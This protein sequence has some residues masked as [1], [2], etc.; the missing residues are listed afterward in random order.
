MLKMNLKNFD[1]I[2]ISFLLIIFFFYNLNRIDYGL[3]FFINLDEN[4]FQ[5]SSLA[6]LK[7]ITGYSG[8]GY[9]PIYGP[10]LNLILILIFIFFNEVIINS[11]SFD[12]IQSKIYFNHELF[13]YYGRIASLTVSTLSIFI[14]YKIFRYLKIKFLIYSTLLISLSTSLY[15]L[16]ISVIN[17]KTSYFL[18]IFLIQLFFFIKYLFEIKK[19]KLKSYI[20]FGFLASLAWG[21]NY[22]AAFVSI[23]AIFFLH[24][25]KYKFFKIR[26]IFIF[27]IIFFIF[28]PLINFLFTESPF[29]FLSPVQAG[30][31]EFELSFFLNRALGDIRECFLIIFKSEKNI[32]LFLAFLPIFLLNK[33]IEIKKEFLIIFFLIFEPI[34]L[35][36]YSGEIFPQL[37]YFVG[38]FCIILISTAIIFNELD[39]LKFKYMSFIIIIFNFFIISNNIYLNKKINQ[40]I[41]KGHSFYQLNNTVI[42]SKDRSKILYLVDL[43]FRESLNQNLFYIKVYENDLIQKYKMQNDFYE[44]SKNKV[45]K[46]RESDKILI[47]NYSLKKD[48]HYFNYTYF[49]IKDL[50]K[51][52]DFIKNDYN[53]IIVE[54]SK[55]FYLS[56]NTERIR[57]ND[58]VEK[59]FFLEKTLFED[60]KIY[61]RTLRSSIHY[62]LD[63]LNPFDLSENIYDKKLDVVYGGNYAMYKLK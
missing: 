45:I 57:I 62:Y 46:I 49:K 11:L 25:K 43:R 8:F 19:F 36:S 50:K 61:L 24:L 12:L 28:G 60:K 63:V 32:F 37:R 58:F 53:Y 29:Y 27:L 44:R 14:L 18:L 5:Y 59:N 40:L 47:D 22:W 26:Y 23:Y 39:K 30:K 21:V 35:L 20:I 34:F 9:N 38:S 48:I 52:F 54:K 15:I 17:G 33:K 4:T 56:S 1:K 10:L 7:F 13:I 51:F 31:E 55:S 16:D 41:S 3:P 6:F 2:F 42:A